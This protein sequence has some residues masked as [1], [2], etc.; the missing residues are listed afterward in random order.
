MARFNA[1]G[2]EGL[3]LSLKEFAEIPDSVVEQMLDAGAEVT[4]SAHKQKLQA[5]GLVDTGQLVN[6]IKPLKKAGGASNGFNRYVLV[7]P[8]GKHGQYNRKKTTKTYKN[9][10]SGRTY[11]VGGDVQDVTNNDIG[12]VYEF[13]APRR[14]IKALQWMKTANEECAEKVTQA[15]FDIYDN[16][17]KSKNL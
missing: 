15:E 16:W 5:L 4:V 2:I 13:G 6:S 7:Y 9:S 17:L 11:D 10:K 14:G 12:F 1:Q 8:A 3:E